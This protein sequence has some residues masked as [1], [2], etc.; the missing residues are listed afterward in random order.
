MTVGGTEPTNAPVLTEPI[1]AGSSTIE[2]ESY[3]AN[4]TIIEVFVNG[5]SV[6]TVT[7]NYHHWILSIPTSTLQS[8]EVVTAKATASGKTESANSAGVT[9]ADKIPPT[10]NVFALKAGDTIINGDVLAPNGSIIDV[11]VNGIQIGSAPVSGNNWSLNVSSSELQTSEVVQARTHI[12]SNNDGN[13]EFDDAKSSLST[14]I[15][16]IDRLSPVPIL[17]PIGFNT[18]VITG[19]LTPVAVTKI[20]VYRLRGGLRTLLGTTQTNS[21]SFFLNEIISNP[22]ELGD[23]I[24]ATSITDTNNDGVVDNNDTQSID[25]DPQIIFDDSVY[26]QP[27]STGS[28]DNKGCSKA[29]PN[30]KPLIYKIETFGNKLKVY[31]NP[32]NNPRN[33]F[34]YE[35]INLNIVKE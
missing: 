1:I 24:T 14:G 12:D 22:W 13:I 35:Y 27:N 26:I 16:V 7:K 6:G 17:D 33:K 31:F 5:V 3:E 25:S 15:T 9:V 21:P 28:S 34:E 20:Y 29:K 18:R 30:G 32:L 11:L 19:S 4:G 2:G 8:G 23:S 10:P